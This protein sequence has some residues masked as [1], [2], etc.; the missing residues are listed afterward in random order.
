[1]LGSEE[2]LGAG[3]GQLLHDVDVRAAAVVAPPGVALGVLVGE[4]AAHGLQHGPGDVVLRGDE[5]Q[6]VALTLHFQFEC[7]EHGG[8]SDAKGFVHGHGS[9]SKDLPSIFSRIASV[10]L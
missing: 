4:V 7:L 3:A 6:V 1:M 10:E 8:V 9:T 2:L 5:L